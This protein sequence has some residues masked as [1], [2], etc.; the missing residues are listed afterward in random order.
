MN[1]QSGRQPDPHQP[2]PH[3][4][5]FAWSELPPEPLNP[6]LTRQFI[7]GSQAMVS[8]IMLKQGALVPEHVHPNEQIS[9]ILSGALE[10]TFPTS[11]LTARAGQIVVIPGSV[12]H[13]ARALEDTE[14][15]DLFAPPREDW[16]SGSDAYLRQPAAR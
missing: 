13:S 3:P 16:L 12:P 5:L 6:L 15:I 1:P 10:F 7:T 14:N 8:R 9:L 4:Q 2:S 11:V